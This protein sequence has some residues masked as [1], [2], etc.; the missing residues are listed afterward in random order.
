MLAPLAGHRENAQ[1]GQQDLLRGLGIV[2]ELVIG[3]VPGRGH[4]QHHRDDDRGDRD[5]RDQQPPAGAGVGELAQL[6]AN[7][8]SERDAGM[9]ARRGRAVIGGSQAAVIALRPC[10]EI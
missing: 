8:A 10:R 1:R 9:L 7:Q 6:G 5:D 2:D 4:E 3:Q